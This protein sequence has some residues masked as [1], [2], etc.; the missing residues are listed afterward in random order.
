MNYIYTYSTSIYLLLGW[1][2]IGQ[3]KHEEVEIRIKQQDGTSCPE[4]LERQSKHSVPSWLSDTSIHNQLEKMGFERVREGREWFKCTVKDV[5]TA[6]NQLI[7][8]VS[9][10]NSYAMREEQKDCH[11]K[12]F[13]HFANGGE[14]FLMNAKMRFG[15][16]FTSYQIMKSMNVKK[17]LILTYKPSVDSSWR[18]DLELHVDF[19]G[20]KYYS[21]SNFSNTN[22]IDLDSNSLYD[23]GDAK[24]KVLFTSFQDF[25]DF[26]KP[27]WKKAKKYHYDM[28][29]IDEMHYGSKTERALQSIDQL[30]F[31]HILY[32]SGTPLKA[33]MSGEFLDEE[34]FTWSY[35]DEQAKRKEE[36]EN[37]WKTET[38]RWMPPM[39]FHTFEVCED[40]KK[41][42]SSYTDEEGFTLTKMFASNDGNKFIDESSVK[43]FVDQLFGRNVKKV[44][45]PIK[46][47]AVD[48]ML[49]VLPPSVNS[50]H[51][52]SKLLEKTIGEDYY[53]ID[54]AGN[55]EDDIDVVKKLI[56][57][58]N[59]TITVSCGRFNTGVTVPEW[60]MVMMLT[61]GKAPETYFQTAFRCQSPN[62]T[63][64]KELC[65][66]IDFNPQRLLELVYRYAE[67]TSTANKS[68]QT[69]LREFLDFAPIF[70]HTGNKPVQVVAEDIFDMIA[71]TGSYV[72][73]FGSSYMLNWNNLKGLEN[74]FDEVEQIKSIKTSKQISDN[75]IVLGSNYVIKGG[76]KNQKVE[77]TIK[78]VKEKVITVMRHI[79]NY[80]FVEGSNIHSVNDIVKKND[81][82]IFDTLVPIPLDSFRKMCYSGLVNVERLNRCIMSYQQMEK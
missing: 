7:H 42:L 56:R 19:D 24:V 51:A 53:I 4:K 80:L 40:A 14:K 12:A 34:I 17:A 32:V 22:H 79:P 75:D 18:E 43:A 59:K 52:F 67:I 65:I 3:T 23:D 74:L 70:D 33:L 55:E 6:I 35:S 46:T 27:K 20:W 15:K 71:K 25:N 48:H 82:T 63:K 37:G 39:Q 78:I 50:V 60:D 16:T 73:S 31:D 77:D 62:K 64:V 47:H 5:E 9:R 76:Q 21:A 13:K 69:I 2:K 72:E 58:H 45:S 66:V 10:P 81:S 41:L 68:P 1:L 61:D 8:G 44:H 28:I 26:N 38:Y 29:V 11:D 49:M 36:E 54:A 30:Q 57:R